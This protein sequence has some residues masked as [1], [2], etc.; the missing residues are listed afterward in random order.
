[1]HRLWL[2]S[3]LG[4]AFLPA[5]AEDNAARGK[6]IADEAL[7][8]LGGEKFL[9]MKDR[10]EAGR[11]YSFY[12]SQL[13]GLAKM[14]VYTRYLTRPEPPKAGFFGLRE[15]QAQGEKE[16]IYVL[17]TETECYETTY[18]GAKP[19]AEETVNRWRESALHN[20]LYIFRQR[21]GEPGLR[22][23]WKKTD[24]Y[25]NMPT[26]IVEFSDDDNRIVTVWFHAS[27]KLPLKQL[28]VRRDPKTRFR[29]EEVTIF[30]KYR[31]VGGGVMWPFVVRRERDGEK[32][33]EMFAETVVINKDLTDDL[34]TI[35]G[36]TKI[37]DKKKK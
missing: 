20:I 7:A 10:T 2:L 23:D 16:D 31:D 37:L 33:Y 11:A 34:F 9:A 24:L 35:S 18:R 21:L 27:T 8:A 3:L 1:M 25:E 26:N 30:S 19:V 28:Y 13:S 32:N 4:A 29:V 14:R 5:R 22:I 17:L 15:R 12:H 6:R 36:A